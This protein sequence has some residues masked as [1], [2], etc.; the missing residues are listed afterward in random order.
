MLLMSA[1]L[2]VHVKYA[3]NASW[4]VLVQAFNVSLFAMKLK[5]VNGQRNVSLGVS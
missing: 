5:I 3:E 2:N 1:T 4:V